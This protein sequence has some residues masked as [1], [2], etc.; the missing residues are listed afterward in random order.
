MRRVTPSQT[1]GPFFHIAF[2]R[3]SCDDLVPEGYEGKPV[4]IT[5]RILDGESQPV[6]D[7]VLEVWQADSQG[8]YSPP[9]SL[10]S[11]HSA[12]SFQGWGRIPTDA[13]GGFRLRT[14]KPGPVIGLKD[15][16][17]APHL[18][19]AIFMRGLLRHLFTRI[20]FEGE[21]A[22]QS[23]PVLLRVA[24]KRRQTLVAARAQAA[25]DSYTWNIILQGP[26]ETVFFDW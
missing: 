15:E 23:D 20:Y 4:T 16:L 12:R 22:N 26:G 18:N 13:L 9:V 1:V 7:A 25:D 5:G 21:P 19:V 2:K 10:L 17:Q 14:I 8:R 11:E 3:L 6:P 24:D